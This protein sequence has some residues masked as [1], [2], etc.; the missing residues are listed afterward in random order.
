MDKKIIIAV[1]SI[2][3][4]TV[5]ACSGVSFGGLSS[6]L[7]AECVGVNDIVCDDTEAYQCQLASYGVGYYV[8]KAPRFDSSDCGATEEETTD[9][10][11]EEAFDS[12]TVAR[13]LITLSSDIE[14]VV[15]DLEDIKEEAADAEADEDGFTLRRLKVELRDVRTTVSDLGDL[16]DTIADE[17]ADAQADGEEVSDVQALYDTADADLTAAQSLE[18]AVSEQ[19]V[20]ALDSLLSAGTDSETAAYEVTDIVDASGSL[21]SYLAFIAYE[22]SDSTTYT[23][24]YLDSTSGFYDYDSPRV[25]TPSV[26]TP[27][28]IVFFISNTDSD[29]NWQG[30][31]GETVSIESDV[32]TI[33]VTLP[34]IAEADITNLY[35]AFYVG[36]DEYLY[37]ADAEHDG[38][39]SLIFLTPEQ[40]ITTDHLVS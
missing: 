30:L 17:I 15:E 28:M 38:E 4:L 23:L 10:E 5:Q 39:N 14:E 1:I 2:L 35:L 21:D 20:N 36:A 3:F 32:S 7:A 18:A 8:S 25:P 33:S 11:T 19:I 6:G 9:G 40:A 34:T 13:K 27:L 37:Y 26:P 24:A 31:N 29:D 16:M 12:E 22:A